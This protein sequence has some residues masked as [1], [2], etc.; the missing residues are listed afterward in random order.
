ML[1][2]LKQMIQDDRSEKVREAATKS[3]ALTLA[4]VDDEDKYSQV[5]Y[6][7]VSL[8]HIQNFNC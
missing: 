1:S 3:L 8:W 5:N 6:S 2:M 7:V 4:F